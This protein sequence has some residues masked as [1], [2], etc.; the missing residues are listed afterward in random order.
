MK[1]IKYFTATILLS[2]LALNAFANNAKPKRAQSNDMVKTTFIKPA[3]CASGYKVIGKK[4]INHEGKKWY[5][6]QCV[7]QQNISPKCNADTDVIKVK[8]K[9]IGKPS[10]GVNNNFKVMMSYECFN[11]VPVE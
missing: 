10:D 1:T 7:Q 3:V 2:S 5:T 8:N 4:L 9:F 6:Y 11:Y